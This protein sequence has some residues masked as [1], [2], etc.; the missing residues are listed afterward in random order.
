MTCAR[1]WLSS[2]QLGWAPSERILLSTI[3]KYPPLTK[4]LWTYA[5]AVLSPFSSKPLNTTAASAALRICCP[6]ESQRIIGTFLGSMQTIS[7]INLLRRRH[8]SLQS[9]KH[10]T[11]EHR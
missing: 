2:N 11:Y 1:Y 5:T 3:L 7:I 8:T 10:L 4:S 9:R 6:H